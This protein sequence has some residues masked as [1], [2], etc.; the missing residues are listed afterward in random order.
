[1][2][3]PRALLRRT[4]AWLLR[5]RRPNCFD[6]LPSPVP[7]FFL[8]L[9]SAASAQE[10]ILAHGGPVRALALSS[11]AAVLAS[12][13]F[14]RSVIF[15]DLARHRARAVARW[16]GGAVHA[17]AALPEGFASAG[18]DGRIALW[19]SAGAAQPLRVLEGHRGPVV[20]LAAMP[21]RLA[22][23][24][25]DGTARV[26]SLDTGESRVLEGHQGNVNGVAFR[27]DGVVATAGADGTLRLWPDGEPPLML[28]EPGPPLNALVALPGG[29]RAVGGADGAVRLVAPDGSQRARA[30]GERPVLALA[31][32]PDGSLLAAAGLG[33]SIGI[34]SVADGRLLQTL[35]GPGFPVWS[36]AFGS[37]GRTLW[38]GGADARIRRW[39]AATGQA[40]GPIGEP[41]TAPAG[42][43]R[44]ARVFRACA[45]CHALTEDGGNRAGPHLHGLF[46]RRMGSVPGYPYSE[47]LA[48][49]DIVWGRETV[50]DLFTRGPDVVTP[51]T[52]MPLQT[53]GNPEEL[54]ALL[55]FLE[56]ATR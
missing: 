23:A 14:D 4:A 7:F 51:G 2:T 52:R 15:W 36:L 41:D 19:P 21:G 26:W 32:S 28:G 38:T 37:D 49:G 31:P 12:A 42:D 13:G 1:M 30:A 29:V 43:D 3:S 47:R 25:W 18:E 39:D 22:S 48:R 20:A 53:V 6:H 54:D 17:L 33:G 44:G 11:D 40:L 24:S 50:A 9:F 27:S 55:R 10:G 34:W 45:A 56:R 16:H 8:L 46:G 35:Q 5:R